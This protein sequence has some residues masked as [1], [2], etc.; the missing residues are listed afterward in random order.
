M[1]G[2]FLTSITR[3]IVVGLMLAPMPA[4]A[5]GSKW[6]PPRTADG[7][8]DMQGTWQTQG[9]NLTVSLEKG[10]VTLLESDKVGFSDASR[11]LSKAFPVGIV[12][13]ADGKI[14]LQPSARVRRK[15]IADNYRD[16]DGNVDYIDPSARCRGAGVPR[17]NYI[18]PYN[19]Y[20]F[21]Q[22][23]GYV[24]LFAEWNHEDPHHPAR[25]ASTRHIRHPAL[26]GRS[27]RPVGGQHVNR[28]LDELQ[29]KG[30]VRLADV[31]QRCLACG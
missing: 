13:P 17:I 28:R 14:P 31:P 2:Q 26:D 18:T 9:G 29:R 4:V 5:Q 21:L 19:G 22:I 11:P 7:Q 15:E 1:G 24:V 27:P 23:P 30:M 20:Q 16:S 8:P 6:I 25:Q 3:A 10:A 12:E